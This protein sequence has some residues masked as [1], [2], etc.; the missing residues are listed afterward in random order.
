MRTYREVLQC[1]DKGRDKT[2]A[3][4]ATSI[5]PNVDNGSALLP[6]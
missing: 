4:R 6:F 2:M 3:K 5:I 1:K